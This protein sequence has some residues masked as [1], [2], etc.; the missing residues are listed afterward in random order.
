MAAVV[1]GGGGA[2]GYAYTST[3]S[4]ETWVQQS[5]LGNTYWGA[6]TSSDD[7]GTLVVAE[8]DGYIHISTNSGST[9]VAQTSAGER[10]WSS[11]TSN[12]DG[13][14]LVGTV[15]GGGLLTLI[16]QP[17]FTLSQST[18]SVAAG[19]QMSGYSILSTGG[20]ISSY[21]ISPD[22]ENGLSFSTSTGQITGTPT[23]AATAK[24]YTITGTNVSGSASRVF[25]ITVTPGLQLPAFTFSSATESATVGAAIAGYTVNSTGGT[26]ASYSISPSISTSPGLAFSTTTGRITGTPTATSGNVVFTVTGTN[27]TGSSSRTFT[28]SISAANIVSITPPA[29]IP[30]LTTVTNPKISLK[31]GKLICTAGTYQSGYTLDGVIQ[32]SP[33]ALLTPASY[34]FNLLINGLAQSSLAKTSTLNSAQ[35]DLVS[36]PNASIAS[37]SVSVSTNSLTNI[38]KSTSNTTG[39]SAANTTLAQATTD[40][41]NA[42]SAAQ[43]ANSTTYQ[44][45]LID[46]RGLWRKQV[47]NI[48][49]NYYETL[50]R[51]TASS[52]SRK[53]ITD[54]STALKVMVAAQKKSAADYKASGPAASAAKDA[55][56]KVALDAKNAAIVKANKSYGTFIE[57]IGYGVLIP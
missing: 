37:C 5:G 16:A 32:G 50:A 36:A 11:L 57:S 9:W 47:E 19:T 22:I 52:A 17:A 10:N 14:K 42:Y 20:H 23:S 27:A 1:G 28:I 2:S 8:Q 15:A 44:K 12:S 54:K 6:V 13:T 39:L 40:A 41:N 45:T 33:S 26:I 3:N 18:E 48:R 38:D 25:T 34:V 49:A 55:A 51:I 53:M 7:G 46:N 56:N 31:E 24:S 4:G 21:S 43:S 35:W 29:P 30:F